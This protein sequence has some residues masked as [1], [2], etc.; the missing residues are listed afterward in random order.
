MQLVARSGGGCYRHCSGQSWPPG[1]RVLGR[2][3]DTGQCCLLGMVRQWVVWESL[4]CCGWF[5]WAKSTELC[6]GGVSD[7]STVDGECQK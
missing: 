3:S 1:A 7:A 2:H 4:G 5:W 6:W